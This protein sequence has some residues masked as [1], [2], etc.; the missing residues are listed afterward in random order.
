MYFTFVALNFTIMRDYRKHLT[1]LP[2]KW[3]NVGFVALAT[4]LVCFVPFVI[5]NNR[6]VAQDLL[7]YLGAAGYILLSLSLML[8]CFSREKEEDEFIMSARY[9]VLTI[10]IFIFFISNIIT[11]M[12]SGGKLLSN[13][14]FSYIGMTVSEQHYTLIEPKSFW[15]IIYRIAGTVS[16]YIYLQVFYVVLLK[17]FVRL[18][19]GNSFESI[20][21]PYRYKKPGW[22]LIIVSL[23]LIPIVV[24]Y[25]GHVLVY[26]IDDIS[27][28]SD[29]ESYIKVYMIVSRILAVIPFIGLMLVCMS[30]ED[31]E[32]EFLCHIRIR[33]L[34]F[35]VFIF[36]L[37]TFLY[38]ISWS[39]QYLI[40]RG[41]T[42]TQVNFHI[43]NLLTIFNN[44]CLF[45]TYPPVMALTYA[46]VLR[47]VLAKNLIES[48]N[49]E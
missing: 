25:L 33:T 16:N 40:S 17:L 44:I 31:Q 6:G 21:L 7:A 46:L 48:S 5:L 36:I 15:G 19:K 41:G 38:R 27:N 1:L 49:E 18:G 39:I 24:Y 34:V 4:I 10:V 8:I 13:T 26:N 30:K 28:H 9:R 43:I 22:I 37:I 32:D 35:F 45:V 47:K 3:Q 29:R 12:I 14:V 23:I 2:H 20:L 11:Q 42:L